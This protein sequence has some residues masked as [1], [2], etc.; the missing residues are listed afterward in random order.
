[1][2]KKKLTAIFMSILL[3]VG[4]LAACGG[5]GS[6][7]SSGSSNENGSDSGGSKSSETIKIGAN[8]ELSGGVATYGQGILEGV[9]LALEEIGDIDGKK[10]EI[11]K[12]DNK[13]DASEAT[14]G[15]LKLVTQD[16]VSAIIGAATSGNTKAQIQIAQDNQIPIIT[17]SGTAEEL[18]VQD[19]KLNDFIFR[20]CFIDPVQGEIAANFAY[21]NL[22]SRNAAILI[23]TGSDYAKG[24]AASFKKVYEE[25]GGKIVSEGAYVAKD[26][27]FRSTLT[28]IKGD[29]PDF[30]YVPGYYEEVGLILKQAREIGLDVPFMGGDGWDSPT[31]LKLAG[32]EALKNV[33]FTNHYSSRDS[34]QK[35]QDFVK[36]FE[37]KYGKKPDAFNALGYDSLYLLA[38][39]I[40]RAG[41]NDPVKIKEALEQTKDL[42]LITGTF[43]YDE[44][45]NPV[46][47]IT[48][49]TFENGEQKFETKIMP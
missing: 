24:L 7:K 14:A 43:T 32:A 9:M 1:M 29:N 34:E 45:H 13:S 41:S 48:I 3:V 49:L 38:D 17:P 18:T 8:L 5:G 2:K 47:S 16:K 11:V 37:E 44:N 26:T 25:K 19:G 10:V 40:K 36:A 42:E 27:D 22:K 30:V 31:L 46:K 23:D 35:I 6:E 12:F 4:I 33:Y 20:T 15:A 21:D 28:T 39:A